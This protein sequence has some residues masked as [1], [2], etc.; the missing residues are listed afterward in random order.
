M[1]ILTA[2][3]LVF[4]PKRIRKIEMDEP[5][6]PVINQPYSSQFVVKLQ[7]RLNDLGFG[8]LEVDGVFGAKTSAAIIA[9]KRSKGLKPRDYV[10]P[11]TKAILFDDRK[12]IPEDGKEPVWLR[13]ARMEIGVKEYKGSRHNSKVLGY[14]KAAFLPFKDDETPWCAGFVAA[15]LEECGIKSPRSGMARSFT[16]WGKKIS[17]PI[18]GSIVVFWRGK[19]DG[20]SGHVGFVT[21][22]DQSGRILCLGGNQSDAVNVK[23][24]EKDRVLGY[25]WPDAVP[26]PDP[27]AKILL[28]SNF[29]PSSSNEA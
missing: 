13:R 16:R 19:R 25:Y 9:F 26:T 3:R 28:A 2:F 21:G 24:F 29:D 27:E 18:P 8:P 4:Q 6:R 14:W 15:M 1:R 10:G 20:A 7:K 17:K 23:P 12:P 22:V 5:E 11:I